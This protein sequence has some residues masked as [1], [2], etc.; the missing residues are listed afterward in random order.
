MPFSSDRDLIERFKHGEISAFE[1]IV[2]RYQDRIY[3]LCRYMVQDARE[4]QDAAQDTFIKAYNGLGNFRP[5]SMLYTWLYRI[6]L[7]TCL[8]YRKKWRREAARREVLTENL[9]SDAP[10]P[11]QIYTAAEIHARIQLALQK[12]PKK[13]S[14]AIVLREF[15]ALS[16]EEIAE[17]L[18]TSVGTVKSRLSRARQQ[19]RHLMKKI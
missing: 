9:P 5:E 4:A 12:L 2:R 6:A 7:N 3:N 18:H 8:D 13:L 11:E 14:T 19:L 17:V 16:Y 15:E 10:F 1:D